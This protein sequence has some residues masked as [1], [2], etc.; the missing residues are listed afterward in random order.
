MYAPPASKYLN[1][2]TKTL[3]LARTESNKDQ[4]QGQS[5]SLLTIEQNQ[6]EKVQHRLKKLTKMN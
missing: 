3:T 4:S 2:K 5:L 1:R 6:M